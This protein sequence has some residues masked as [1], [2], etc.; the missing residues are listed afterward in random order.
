MFFGLDS[1]LGCQLSTSANAFH[2]TAGRNPYRED[3]E[4]VI[5][6]EEWIKERHAPIATAHLAGVVAKPNRPTDCPCQPLG[7][8]R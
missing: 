1:R 8:Y 5:M 6:I 2:E 3:F 4:V 7:L